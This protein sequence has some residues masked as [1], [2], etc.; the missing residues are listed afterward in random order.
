MKKETENHRTKLLRKNIIVSFFAKGWSALVLLLIVPVT[1]NCLGEYTNGVWL[2][3][4]SLLLWI[5]NM[6]IGLGN[7]LRNKL[8]ICLAHDDIPHAQQLISSAFAM[9]LCI[10]IPCMI[11]LCTLSLLCDTYSFLNVMPQKIPHLNR[12]LII[13]IVLVCTTFIFKL[14]GNVYMGLQLPA[15][16]N[17]LVA[18]GQTL[19]LIGTYIAYLTGSHSLLH[20][21]L[22][23][24]LAPLLVY[25]IAYSI[26]FFYK[27][28]S[29][30]PT[31]QQV[32]LKEAKEVMTI[33]IKFF[34]LQISGVVLFMSSNILIS[35]LF[36]PA[37][38][39]PY[40]ITYRYFFLLQAIF[41]VICTP[42]WNAT[43]D[44]YER[45]DMVWV[46]DASKKLNL[47]T[48]YIL[49]CAI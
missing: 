26:T 36:N 22:I 14:T 5:D 34:V 28:P 42:Y 20:I 18:A 45:K 21:A 30:R 44:A 4:S 8:A 25:F 11:L 6:D 16:N 19:T 12:V 23:N 39:T 3:I 46:K 43:T 13:T 37:M 38:V 2:T 7:G 41:T 29:L 27:Y 33:G 9:L 31:R 47:M 1:L 40:Q 32:S 15:V 24:T 48:L 49:I 10:M 17:L 35:K